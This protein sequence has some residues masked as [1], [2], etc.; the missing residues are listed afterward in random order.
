MLAKALAW[1]GSLDVYWHVA[2]AAMR[3]ID[4]PGELVMTDSRRLPV[5]TADVLASD[6]LLSIR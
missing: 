5:S 4:I 3:A 2:A 6:G 1:E